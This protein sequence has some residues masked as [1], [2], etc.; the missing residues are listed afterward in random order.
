MSVKNFNLCLYGTYRRR[1]INY[2]GQSFI[3]TRGLS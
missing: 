3:S 1:M 2:Y